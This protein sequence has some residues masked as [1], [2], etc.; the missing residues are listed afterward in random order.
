M[1][2]GTSSRLVQ[3]GVLCS[4][5]YP[6]D[7]R[8]F[9]VFR[10]WWQAKSWTCHPRPRG[11]PPPPDAIASD[12]QLPVLPVL[13]MWGQYFH[14]ITL[15]VLKAH[16]P[17]T[18]AS[19]PFPLCSESPP[20]PPDGAAMAP[21]TCDSPEGLLD[22]LTPDP[23]YARMSNIPTS[24]ADDSSFSKQTQSLGQECAP[25]PAKNQ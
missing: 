15:L 4:N 17:V 11:D 25:Q 24:D 22:A 2:E 19:N 6:C 8:G 20:Q 7:L 5:N 21:K 1:R 10:R 12:W 23:F 3:R 14:P 9:L 18:G 13:H 16:L